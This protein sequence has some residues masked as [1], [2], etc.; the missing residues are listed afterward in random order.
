MLGGGNTR[1][2]VTPCYCRAAKEE[3]RGVACELP[4][5]LVRIRKL[6][7]PLK[8]IAVGCCYWWIDGVVCAMFCI[9]IGSTMGDADG[10]R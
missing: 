2:N 1:R 8:C 7:R 6:P 3:N 9:V 4:K 10:V 5:I